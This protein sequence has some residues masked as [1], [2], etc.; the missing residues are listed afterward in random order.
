MR[1]MLDDLALPQVQI[2]RLHDRRMLA[3]HRAPTMDGSYLQN[4]GR[5]AG[6]IAVVGVASG[7][8]AQAFLEA[9]SAKF[10]AGEPLSFV[11][12]II[13]DAEIE[14][15][16]IDDLKVRDLAG[17]PERYAYA[18]ILH[19]HR[20]PPEPEDFSVLQD[21]LLGDASDLID[22][23]TEGLGLSLDFTIGLERFVGSLTDLLGR[24]QALNRGNG[25]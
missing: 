14:A 4:L 13:A 11:G 17:K 10:D 7:P 20:E 18:L 21:E 16:L 8:T 1:P 22:D 24:L 15:V 9:L 2:L 5:R 6:A 3:E 23:L 12:D 19:E 25:G